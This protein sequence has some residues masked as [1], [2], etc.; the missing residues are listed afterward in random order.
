MDW[1]RGE[2][3]GKGRDEGRGERKEDTLEDVVDAAATDCYE[4]FHFEVDFSVVVI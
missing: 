4:A 2:T 3:R 1:G